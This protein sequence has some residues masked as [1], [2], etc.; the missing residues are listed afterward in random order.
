MNKV[1][2]IKNKIHIKLIGWRENL[3]NKISETENFIE[4]KYVIEFYS[5]DELLNL[6]DQILKVFAKKNKSDSATL[7]LLDKSLDDQ[8]FY[9]QEIEAIDFTSLLDGIDEDS[10]EFRLV[11]MIKKNS[12]SIYSLEK[13]LENIKGLEF[14]NILN[15]FNRFTHDQNAPEYLSIKELDLQL[16]STLCSAEENKIYRTRYIALMGD[17]VNAFGFPVHSLL[18]NDFNF[19]Y[20]G[21]KDISDNFKTLFDSL[22]KLKGLLSLFFLCDFIELDNNM[23]KIKLNN[24][25]SFHYNFDFFEFSFSSQQVIDELFEIYQWVYDNSNTEHVHDKLELARI[26]VAK[27]LFLNGNTINLKN[28]NIVNNLNSMYKIYLKENVNQYIEATN[29]V[30]EIVSEMNYKQGEITSSFTNSL[31]TNSTLLI[32]FFI[33]L[34]VY[35]NLAAGETSIFN[36]SNF[37]LVVLFTI[38]STASLILSFLQVN[39]NLKRTTDYFDKQKEIYLHLFSKD[40]I[41][42]LFSDEYLEKIKSNVE[43][44]RNLYT[45]V[46]ISELILILLIS[47]TATFHPTLLPQVVEYLKPISEKK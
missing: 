15:N 41:N 25:Y 31:K 7:E 6:Q 3:L 2:V 44:E 19:N 4:Y 26:Q 17:S 35:N 18:P 36:N 32:G 22:E 45:G 14:K 1:T 16:I 38:I 28:Y 20:S 46:W 5:K 12:F 43:F 27:N 39:R 8:I 42:Q 21:R 37:I 11:L 24:T 13:F 10:D 33:S 47:Y 9:E 30:A 40:D 23:I 34:V 29:K